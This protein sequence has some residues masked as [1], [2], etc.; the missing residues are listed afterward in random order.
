[1][2]IIYYFSIVFNSRSAFLFCA[3]NAFVWG[4]AGLKMHCNLRQGRKD[5]QHIRPYFL[6]RSL[7][8]GGDLHRVTLR[9]RQSPH[10]SRSVSKSILVP[11]MTCRL[12]RLLK[13]K[14]DQTSAWGTGSSQLL[15]I[16]LS[17]T[18]SW[19][20]WTWVITW[21][22]IPKG[23]EYKNIDT[24]AKMIQ[25][26]SYPLSRSVGAKGNLHHDANSILLTEK[27]PSLRC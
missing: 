24:H 21:Q 23:V 11:S 16:I 26:S 25:K 4:F 9:L 2:C 22:P 13:I 6:R 1:M 17:K 3:Y 14:P 12:V 20:S 18:V 27:E 10:N 19:L 15:I 5:E 7:G 8:F